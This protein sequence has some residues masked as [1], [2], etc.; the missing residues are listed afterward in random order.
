MRIPEQLLFLVILAILIVSPP[1]AAKTAE[2]SVF[3]DLE[4]QKTSLAHYD[5]TAMAKSIRQETPDQFPCISKEPT[6]NVQIET[7]PI[8]SRNQAPRLAITENLTLIDDFEGNGIVTWTYDGFWHQV[9]SGQTYGESHSPTHSMWYGND[10]SGN[11]DNGSA[12]SGTL[13]SSF[14]SLASGAEMLSFWSWYETETFLTHDVKEVYI[15]LPNGTSTLLGRVNG[16]KSQWIRFSF[17]ITAFAGLDVS[18]GFQFNTKDEFNN[19]FRGWYIDDVEI[20]VPVAHNLIVS[21]ETPTSPIPDNSYLINASVT[22]DGTENESAVV[23]SLYLNSSSVKN[24]TIS[25]L[26]SN[27]TSTISYLWTA[28]TLDTYNFTVY[29]MPVDGE[30]LIADNNSSRFLTVVDNH[31]E[32]GYIEVTVRWLGGDPIEGAEVIVTLGYYEY[33]IIVGSGFTDAS[34]FYNATGLDIGVYTVTASA[35]A[36]NWGE[37]GVEYVDYIGDPEYRTFYL[38]P[39]ILFPELTNLTDLTCEIDSNL[40]L[41]WVPVDNNPAN[42]TVFKNSGIDT[43]GDWISGFPITASLDSLTLGVYNYTLVVEDDDDNLANDTVFVTV[44]P[45]TFAPQLSSK[46]KVTYEVG[47]TNNIITWTATDS[48]PGSYSITQDSSPVKS[49]IWT[50]NVPITINID[51]LLVGTYSY[52]ITVTDIYDNAASDTVIVTVVEVDIDPPV[53]SH[54]ADISYR[55]GSVGNYIRWI[56][57]DLNP[58]TYTI[59]RNNTVAFSGYWGSE[60]PIIVT[61]DGLAAG[62][63][64]YTIVVVDHNG[65]S[66]NDT[67]VVMVLGQDK[68]VPVISSPGDIAYEKGSISFNISWA[69]NDSN[70]NS[71][72]IS[73]DGTEIDSGPWTVSTPIVINV[74]GLEKG[75]YLYVIMVTDTHGNAAYDVVVVTVTD[76]EEEATSHSEDRF[77]ILS[78]VLLSMGSVTLLLL[79][80]GG[81][82]LLRRYLVSKK[83]QEN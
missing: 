54:P 63:Y 32:W 9:A 61:L 14:V 70:P 5:A 21:L 6:E 82:L 3:Q 30:E 43:T 67:V 22:N 81:F 28:I 20:M 66:A 78:L 60:I 36:S 59:I 38:S 29:A 18:F 31:K 49:D 65:N 71:Y 35:A 15:L 26:A 50:S 46:G 1:S 73:R 79:A 10:S 68:T 17:N 40:N 39:T 64:P 19:N 16:T 62:S 33:D 74:D 58:S 55:E 52:A 42:Y 2:S 12:N 45:D 13:N 8:A 34:G 83:G 69:A 23:L 80:V 7:K 44:V 56:A 24:T 47:S 4:L 41:S 48:N 53:I 72:F 37:E 77:G 76:P 75:S 57:S 27:E 11:Y 51:G 25:S